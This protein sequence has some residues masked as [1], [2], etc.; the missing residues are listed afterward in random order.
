MQ[1]CGAGEMQVD[2]STV[3]S[4]TVELTTSKNSLFAKCNITAKCH[5][6]INLPFNTTA[7][8][9]LYKLWEITFHGKTCPACLALNA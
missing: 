9:G 6:I 1:G 3:D 2:S 5:Y 7:I 8:D 4:S